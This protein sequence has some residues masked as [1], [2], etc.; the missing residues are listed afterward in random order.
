MAVAH[1]AATESHT[2]TTGS[3]NEASFTW[4]HAGAS[5]GVK[6]ILVFVYTTNTAVDLATSVTYDG[7]NVPAVAGGLAVDT[8][9]EIGQC[10][11]FF[12]GTGVAQGTKAVVVNR[13]NNGQT[14]WGVSATQLAS[15]DL[16]YTGVLI[17]EENQALTEE[18][19][20][21][22]SPGTNSLRYAGAYS[23]VAN[24]TAA[25]VP[26]ANSTEIGAID[27]G[28]FVAMAVR[29][30]TAGQ[31]SRPVGMVA[32]TDDVAAVYLAIREPATSTAASSRM[33]TMGVG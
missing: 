7:A 8:L 4:D 22:G 28:A 20:D 5:S 25:L 15:G 14:M 6:G 19:I 27:F 31:G 2:G 16:E 33:M 9:T 26:G 11:A 30:T 23:G 32:A 10:K 3:T 29:E 12:L 24:V 21:D 17:E 13:T 18:N 1:D